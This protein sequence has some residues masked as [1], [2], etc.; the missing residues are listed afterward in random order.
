[1][2]KCT[3]G[4]LLKDKLSAFHKPIIRL[5]VPVQVQ[6]GKNR[7]VLTDKG[8]QLPFVSCTINIRS[9]VVFITSE[10]LN[11]VL[12][13]SKAHTNQIFN[14]PSSTEY[15]YTYN[16]SKYLCLSYPMKTEGMQLLGTCLFTFFSQALSEDSY[17]QRREVFT[18]NN[19]LVLSIGLPPMSLSRSY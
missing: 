6:V 18:F 7:Q 8:E 15:H 13:S 11:L 2:S 1:M 3:S 10:L 5:P 16:Y 9:P 14:K 19:P 17:S 12:Y 4:I